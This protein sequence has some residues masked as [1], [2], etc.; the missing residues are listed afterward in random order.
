MGGKLTILIHEDIFELQ[1]AVED[2]ELVQ[3]AQG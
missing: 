1:V 3:A 2:V